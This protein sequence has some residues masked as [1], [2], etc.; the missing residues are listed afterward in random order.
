VRRI[1]LIPVYNE[2]ST[3]VSVLDLLSEQVDG[4]L[5]VDDGS[6]DGSL[7]LAQQWASQHTG[8]EILRMPQNQGMSTALREGFARVVELLKKGALSAE[9]ILITID[10]DG[11]HDSGEIGYL[12]DYMEAHR[13]DVALARRDFSLYPTHKRLGNHVMT[14]W[15]RLWSGFSYRDIESGF[16]AMRIKVLPAI[17]EYYTGYRYSCAQEIAVLT[18]RLGFRVDN[19]F[20]TVIR[21][22][23]SQTGIRD[24]LVNAGFGFWAF[25]RWITGRKMVNRPAVALPVV[26]LEKS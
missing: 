2:A 7:A 17:L 8:V 21:L 5:M 18:A 23:R 13:L 6:V 20:R 16:R 19:Q 14:L 3:L 22:Y 4:L 1:A 25:A 11:Q 15:G 10:A 9:D 12:C 26:T 24:V